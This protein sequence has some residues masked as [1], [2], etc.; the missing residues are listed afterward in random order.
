MVFLKKEHNQQLKGNVL[1]KDLPATH[2]MLLFL[3]L[4]VAVFMFILFLQIIPELRKS[5]DS[6]M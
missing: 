2:N 5:K 3:I 6:D 4:I 1:H